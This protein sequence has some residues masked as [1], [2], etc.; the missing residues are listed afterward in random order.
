MLRIFTSVKIQ[1]LRSG[2]NPRPRVPEASMLTTRPP[3]P[4]HCCVTNI[5]IET[6]SINFNPLGLKRIYQQLR[7]T[8]HHGWYMFHVIIIIIIITTSPDD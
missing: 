1:R 7:F 2:L 5:H 8:C 3:K 6:I 4:S